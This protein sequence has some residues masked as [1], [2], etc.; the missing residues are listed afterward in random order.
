MILALFIEIYSSVF[1]ST[2]STIS[3]GRYAT[4]NAADM[5]TYSSIF[6]S[7]QG[8]QRHQ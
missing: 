2:I 7:N 8:Y 3:D 4:K 5:Q 6:L 1:L